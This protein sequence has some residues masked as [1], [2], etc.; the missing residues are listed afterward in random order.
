MKNKILPVFISFAGCTSRCIYC[1][2][3]RITGVK[4]ENIISSAEEQIQKYMSYQT[5]WDEIAFYGGSFTCIP[6]VIR[7]KLYELAHNAGFFKIRFST[8]PDCINEKV[9][10]EAVKNGV[11]TVE[12]GVQSLD[13]EVLQA[14][15]RPYT[16]EECISAFKKIKEKI[17]KTGIQLMAGLYKDDFDKYADTIDRALGMGADYARIYPCA[18]LEDTVLA[19]LFRSGDYTPL[20]LSEAL[21]L[22]SYAYILLTASG[23]EVIRIGLHS[24]GVE[25]GILAGGYHPAMG[26]MVKT[27]AML[28]YV[29]MGGKIEVEQKYLNIAYGYGGVLKEMFTGS[30]SMKNGAKPDFKSICTTIMEKTGENYKRKLKEQTDNFAKRLIDKTNH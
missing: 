16:S 20:E 6:L 29:S 23:C 25:S 11:H 12:L 13:D 8:S 9:L 19:E 2:Q 27:V 17:P 30:V 15:R 4:P 26:D 18:V 1:N 14:N 21:S 3:H 5:D 24:D 28:I 10:D 22:C 7:Q